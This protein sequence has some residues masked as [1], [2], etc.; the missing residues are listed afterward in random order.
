MT[1]R[2][3]FEPGRH[4]PACPSV[5]HPKDTEYSQHR[6]REQDQNEDE[7]PNIQ[8]QQQHRFTASRLT[9]S[10]CRLP[11]GSYILQGSE[12]STFIRTDGQTDMADSIFYIPN[13]YYCYYYYY[14]CQL[15]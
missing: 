5:R 1:A 11:Y 7:I 2:E 3:P 6:E 15:T 9:R 8:Q 4:C 14:Y 10:G 13:Y 12:I